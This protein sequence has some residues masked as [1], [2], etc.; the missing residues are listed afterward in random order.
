MNNQAT[1]QLSPIVPV[2][3]PTKPETEKPTTTDKNNIVC[4][5]GKRKKFEPDNSDDD[6]D[7][8][9]TSESR[10][11]IQKLTHSI[12]IERINS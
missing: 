1:I 9:I 10:K 8:V 11:K 5:L 7:S 2:S 12:T 3:T 4:N 6:L